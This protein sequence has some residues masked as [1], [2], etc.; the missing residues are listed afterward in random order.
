MAEPELPEAHGVPNIDLGSMPPVIAPRLTPRAFAAA[1]A[2]AEAVLALAAFGSAAPLPVW[3]LGHLAL[4]GLAALALLRM[5]PDL[6]DV[7]PYALAV[8]ASLIG[9]P[10]GANFA[11]VALM[12]RA[13]EKPH[14]EL[15]AAWYD[16]IALAGDIDPVTALYNTV[17]MGRAVRTST[18]PPE[19]FERVMINGSLEDRQTCLGLIARQFTPSYAPALRLA[20]VSP[21]PVIRVQAAA[22]A[23]KVRGELKATFATAL[24]RARSEVLQPSAAAQL[25]HALHDMVGSQLLEDEDCQQGLVTIG[26]LLQRAAADLAA[27]GEAG[28]PID[29]P[30]QALLETELLRRGH[31]AAFRVQRGQQLS[32]NA[33][34]KDAPHV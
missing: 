11:V 27:G 12:W 32:G 4:T 17:A 3:L 30:S 8:I 14:P 7:S 31:Y 18:T 15:L 25:A 9:G 13:R 20:L 22:V 23:V 1:L 21:E 10:V 29:A 26:T 33:P 28:S 19:M 2:L 24:T 16:R 34:V 6:A 5:Q